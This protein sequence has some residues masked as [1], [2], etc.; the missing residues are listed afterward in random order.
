MAKQPNNHPVFGKRKDVGTKVPKP[1]VLRRQKNSQYGIKRKRGS[2]ELSSE[3]EGA[4]LQTIADLEEKLGFLFDTYQYSP[5]LEADG[6]I[7]FVPSEGAGSVASPPRYGSSLTEFDPSIYN[8]DIV[9][10]NKN[11]VL[12]NES[13]E[14]RSNLREALMRAVEEMARLDGVPV[15][16]WL[17]DQFQLGHTE[18]TG[19]APQTAGLSSNSR[20]KKNAVSL[21]LEPELEQALS[22][23]TRAS[24]FKQND[25]LRAAI[26]K[27][28]VEGLEVEKLLEPNSQEGSTKP[29]PD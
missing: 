10:N 24:G 12:S 19:R 26:V 4:R 8:Q 13:L 3:L 7:R 22:A 20:V 9:N 14:Q 27:A 11:D 1:E 21:R 23:A 16:N 2:S 18:V 6:S 5:V 25:W 15:R 28:L 17:V 29:S